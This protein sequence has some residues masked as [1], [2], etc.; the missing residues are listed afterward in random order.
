MNNQVEYKGYVGEVSVDMEVGLIHGRVI[1]IEDDVLTFRGETPD[2][3][4]QDFY[5][6][7]NEY[8]ADCAQDG[9]RA[10]IPKAMAQN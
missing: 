6:V 4:K 10:A 8:L 9:V 7:I 5:E 1:N 3:A 2:E